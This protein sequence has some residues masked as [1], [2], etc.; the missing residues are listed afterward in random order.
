L[1]GLRL[2]LEGIHRIR[3]TR[4]GIAS[5]LEPMA[6]GFPAYFFPGETLDGLQVMGGVMVIAAIILRQ[7]QSEEDPRDPAFPPG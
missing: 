6:A 4:A 5:A 3:A 7:L 2:S 1:F